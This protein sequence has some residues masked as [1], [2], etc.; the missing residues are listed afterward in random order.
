MRATYG[1]A[2]ALVVLAFVDQRPTSRPGVATLAATFDSDR[3]FVERIE[4]LLPPDAMVYQ[5][6]YTQFPE[7]PPLHREPLYSPMRMFV[8]SRHLRWSY[9]GMKGRPGDYW[10]QA[11]DRLSVPDRLARIRARVSPGSCSIG[12]RC[13]TPVSRTTR[14]SPRSGPWTGSRAATA[15]SLLPLPR[16]R[17]RQRTRGG[18]R[19]G[20]LVRGF[21]REEGDPPASVELEQRQC[22]DVHPSSRR[23]AASRWS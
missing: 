16:N 5:L 23:A 18:R 15:R 19:S 20:W 13:L 9:G 14:R 17:C 22:R 8:H 21:Y 4:R 11:L 2:A 10:H 6:P 7:V 3:A 12:R 1:V